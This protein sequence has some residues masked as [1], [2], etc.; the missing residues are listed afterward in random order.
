M[1]N[2]P[3]LIDEGDAGQRLDRWLQQKYGHI[4]YLFIQKAIR[5]GDIRLN[6]KKVDGAVRLESGQLLRLPPAFY[7]APDPHA[8]R[9]LS[10]DELKQAKW[11]VAY[12]DDFVLGLNKPHGLATQGGTK[13]YKHVDR[14]LHAF[15]DAFGDRPKLVHRL[16][17]D[18]SGIM[19]A[20]KNRIVAAKLG[21]SFK[22]REVDKTYLAITVGVPRAHRDTINRPLLKTITPDGEKV[23][24]DREGKDAVTIYSVLSFAGQDLALVGLRPETGRMHQLRAHLAHINTPILGD[25]KYGGVLDFGPYSEASKERLW[26]HAL[27]LHLPHPVTEKPLDLFAPVPKAMKDTLEKWNMAVPGVTDTQTPT[28]PMDEAGKNFV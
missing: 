9:P 12:E 4:T 23:V 10:P 18:T 24:V 26:L 3:I 27:Y 1:K 7:H 20:A 19:I 16:D 17:K 14:L 15:T 5:K 13:T 28:D 25:R 22:Q 21:S 11:M 6:G 2:E 8:F